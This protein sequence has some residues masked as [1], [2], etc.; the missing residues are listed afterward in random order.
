MK[1]KYLNLIILIIVT[2]LVTLILYSCKLFGGGLSFN[3]F[4]PSNNY[5]W[6]EVD[7]PGVGVGVFNSVA[8]GNNTFVAVG[9]RG[10]IAVSNDSPDWT[11]W[12]LIDPPPTVSDLYS[13]AFGNNTFVA[14]GDDGGIVVSRD[15][16]SSWTIIDPPPTD[17]DLISIAFGNN[18]F[19]AVGG[20]G[21]TGVTI[22]VGRPSR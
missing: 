10:K 20:I 13:I 16:G 4:S 14:V 21:G 9:T 17:R 2:I 8:F 19:V 22:V 18:T 7:I 3:S 15:N 12:T 1:R 6:T 5:T 11:T